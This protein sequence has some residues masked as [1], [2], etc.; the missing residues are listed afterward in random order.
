MYTKQLLN[1]GVILLL[2]ATA[3][4]AQNLGEVHGNF[5]TDFQYYNK[6]SLIGAPIVPEKYRNN[7]FS[8]LIYNRGNLTAGVRFES[9]LNE[10][11]GF[12]PRYRGAG[13]PFKYANYKVDNLDITVGNF[14][15]QYGSGLVFRSYE[16]RALG[17]DNAMEGVKIKYNPIAGIYIK[18]FTGKQRF[19]FAQG[20]GIVRGADGEININ[21][22]L[23]PLADKPWKVIVGGSF[24]SKY[25]KD[26][27]PVY[28][29]PENVGTW[30]AR[31]NVI[32]G[33]INVFAEYAYKINDPSKLNNF[34]YKYGQGLLV[35]AGYSQKGLGISLSGKYVDNMAF[36]S[37]RTA[38]GNTLMINYMPA[39]TKQHTYNLLSTLYPYASQPT[40]EIDFQG[41]VIYT[42]KKG[43]R[44]GGEYGTNVLLNFSSANGLDTT[45]TNDG[46]GYS[47]NNKKLGVAYFRDANIEISRKINK[48]LKLIGTYANLLYNTDF[49]QGVKGKEIVHAHVGVLEINYKI[50]SVHA[51]KGE[52]QTLF[53]KQDKGN[54]VTAFVEYTVSPHYFFALMD[55]YNVVSYNNLSA[56]YVEHNYGGTTDKIYR[57]HYPYASVGYLKNTSRIA[58]NYGKQRAGITCIGGVCRAV[59]A[60][61]GFSVSI[62]TTF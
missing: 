23:K 58:V 44:L 12:D 29:L 43:S 26:D 10:I 36:R 53:T 30:A 27:D 42:L 56:K 38:T 39:L 22:L 52:L 35:Q 59:P 6:D 28:K 54:W 34:T 13:I 19:F 51:I 40:G 11:L 31:M 50:N 25:Q 62:T 7:T 41:E 1:I 9:Y 24:V 45:T 55:Q 16:E 4:L 21:E 32:R 8:N 47:V 57:L 5:Q 14:Y 46:L 48:K 3:T 37:D 61:N 49:V 2:N 17:Y 20:P 60:S 33:K 18:G 15:E